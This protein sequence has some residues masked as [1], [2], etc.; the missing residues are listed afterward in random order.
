MRRGS[1]ALAAL[2]MLA[3]MGAPGIAL[4]AAQ[5]TAT[6]RGTQQQPT[7]RAKAS[8]ADAKAARLGSSTYRR[9][10]RAYVG[11]RYRATVRQHQRHAAKARNRRRS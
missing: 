8:T 6:E 2:A 11:K 4:T 5:A 1:S 10:L 3:S 7:E 9:R